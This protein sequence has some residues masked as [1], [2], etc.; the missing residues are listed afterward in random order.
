ME[1]NELE[2]LLFEDWTWRKT[3]ISDLILL[4]ETEEKYVLLKSIILLLYSHW[5]GYIKKSSKTYLKFLCNNKIKISDLTE[6][7]R[8]VVLKGLSKEVFKSGNTLSLSNEMNL[9]KKF[10]LINDLVIG[11][12]LTVDLDSEKDKDIIDTQ[13]NL[14]PSVFKNILE[15]IGLHYNNQYEIKKNHISNDL[16]AYRNSIG[17]GNRRLSKDN[18]FDLNINS[19]KRLRD[20]IFAIVENFRDELNYFAQKEFYLKA[21]QGEIIKYVSEKELELEMIFKQIDTRYK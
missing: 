11:K 5:E 17:H 15:I 2:D 7:F 20:I 8:A 13:D 9:I 1:I 10:S 14:N 19:L 18:N 16:L 12:C 6:N 21:N 4:A 3:E